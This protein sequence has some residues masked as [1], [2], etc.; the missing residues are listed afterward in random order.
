MKK[1][2]LILG[3]AAILSGCSQMNQYISSSSDATAQQKFRACALSEAQSKLKNGTLFSQSL[4]ETK[5]D[6]VNTCIK[7][8]ALEAAGIDEE[9]QSI[10]TSIINN[11]RNAQ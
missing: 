8:M 6:I 1:Y 7:K 3:I 11:L 10:A 2:A 4:T 9:A 5:D